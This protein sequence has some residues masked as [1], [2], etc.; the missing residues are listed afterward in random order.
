MID[1][2][3]CDTEINIFKT[4]DKVEVGYKNI[5]GKKYIIK[6]DVIIEKYNK[7]YEFEFY[8]EFQQKIIADGMNKNI[9][10]PIR[11]LDCE[12]N[13]D[14]NKDNNKKYIYELINSDFDEKYISKLLYKDWLDYTIQ[15]CLTIYYL[16]Y[17][18]GV[19]HNDL[20]FRGKIRNVMINK[21][22]IPFDINVEDFIY[23]IKNNYTVLI[24][25]GHQNPNKLLRTEEFYNSEYINNEVRKQ[26]IY[27]SEVFIIFYYCYKI[28]FKLDDRWGDNYFQTYNKFLKEVGTNSTVKNFDRHIIKSLLKL[29]SENQ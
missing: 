5:S 8:K 27:K 16:N 4:N 20:C 21:N 12:S 6:N 2:I 10:L 28:F 26:L 15:L 19:Y 29:Q 17:V 9:L 23:K 3:T 24:D 11:I 1:K 7:L 25:F 13:K 18:L 14:K 22:N